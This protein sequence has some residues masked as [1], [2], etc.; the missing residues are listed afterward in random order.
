MFTYA[1]GIYNTAAARNRELLIPLAG[2]MR[3]G[4][5]YIKNIGSHIWNNIPTLIRTKGTTKCFANAL[6]NSIHNMLQE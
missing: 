5:N 4:L 3:Y 1:S 6:S 2:T